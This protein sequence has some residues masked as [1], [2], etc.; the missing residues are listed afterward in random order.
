MAETTLQI[1]NKTP[2]WHVFIV[3]K[4]R[5]RGEIQNQETTTKLTQNTVNQS[6][7]IPVN[8]H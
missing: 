4:M 7:Q 5:V 3:I 2:Y 6:Y 8:K 1:F